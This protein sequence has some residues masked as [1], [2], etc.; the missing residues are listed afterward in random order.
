MAVVKEITSS[1]FDAAGNESLAPG[2]QVP[3][4]TVLPPDVRWREVEVPD[5]DPEPAPPEPGPP[6]AV[7]SDAPKRSATVKAETAQGKGS[8]KP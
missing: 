1:V 7:P 6:P 2:T 5:P 3:W 8:A 4:D